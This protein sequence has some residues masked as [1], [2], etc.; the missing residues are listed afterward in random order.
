MPLL[1]FL[2][3][4]YFLIR[5]VN[6]RLLPIFADEAIYIRWAQLIWRGQIF[7]PLSDGKPPLFMW[8]LAP[9]L[10]LIKDPL[11]AG[12]L[13]S[14]LAGL[15]TLLG[16]YVLSKK[17][18][19]SAVA[20]LAAVLVI[21]QPFLIFYD[22][23]SLVDSLLTALGIWI[24]YLSYQLF[25]QPSWKKGF[26]LG[27]L[28]AAGLLT[29]PAAAMFFL[30]IPFFLILFPSQKWFKKIKSLLIPGT[31][32]LFVSLGLY[33]LQ[34]LSQVFYMIN[35]RSADY[36]R[37]PQEILAQLSEYF[38]P[39]AKV[40][41]YWL[42][43]YLSWP[44]LVLLLISLI[45]ALLKKNQK[46]C[47][48]FLWVLLPFLIE[49]ITGKIIYP[50]YLLIIVPFIL[51]ITAWGVTTLW[52]L[53]RPKFLLRSSL[54]LLISVLWIYYLSFDWFILTNPVAAPLID[55]EKDQYLYSWSAGFGI[56]EI[57]SYLN[58]LPRDQEIW[59]ATEGSFGTLPNGL[60]I[61]FERSPNIRIIGLGF[62]ENPL[63]SDLASALAE[64]K[65]IYLV[66]NS[67]RFSF[68]DKKRLQLIAEYPRPVSPQ[69]QEKLLFLKVLD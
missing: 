22:R 38:L 44:L 15:A 11:L 30:L 55:W 63:N 59:V 35:R 3:G 66:G 12:R 67:D 53:S 24:F 2:T 28:L 40:F 13:L 36:L 49:I 65:Q 60:E 37:S 31:L 61:Y 41:F 34:R 7:V 42:E 32:A 57:V 33:N 51:I 20:R 50:R 16:V 17:L 52:Q 6:L 54:L 43:S 8:L 48:L 58:Q 5:L 21:F 1:A 4:L 68:G 27:F 62:P 69:G 26:G 14:V 9:W 56:K 39:T 25:T 23:L 29:K 47:L 10:Q 18:F 46:V 64:G 45:L 19:S